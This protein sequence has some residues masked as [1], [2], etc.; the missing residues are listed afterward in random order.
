M[1]KFLF[2]LLFRSF[3]PES[4]R[5][6]MTVGK[7]DEAAKI[8]MKLA[9]T[10]GVKVAE[11]IPIISNQRSKIKD[12]KLFIATGNIGKLPDNNLDIPTKSCF[13]TLFSG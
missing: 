2:C 11:V 12:G 9:N 3:T 1:N 10:N 6:L 13:P 8:M 7:I 5:W 4:P